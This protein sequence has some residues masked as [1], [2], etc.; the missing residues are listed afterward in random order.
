MKKKLIV[1]SESNEKKWPVYEPQFIF[2]FVLLAIVE[3]TQRFEYIRVRARIINTTKY[4]KLRSMLGWML[5]LNFKCAALPMPSNY[6]LTGISVWQP[7]LKSFN[8]IFCDLLEGPSTH[9]KVSQ[10]LLGTLVYFV[11]IIGWFFIP[12]DR[13]A[14]KDTK[15]QHLNLI[16][17]MD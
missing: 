15:S 16:Q 8:V 13:I 6:G 9:R 1:G 11:R 5:F 12:S 7:C 4:L 2:Y 10:L 14:W 17:V 3:N